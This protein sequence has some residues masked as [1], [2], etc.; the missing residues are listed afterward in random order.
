MQW[1]RFIIDKHVPFA[2]FAGLHISMWSLNPAYFYH[3]GDKNV[4]STM[5]LIQ[6]RFPTLHYHMLQC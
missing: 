3:F 5:M 2:I 6:Q 4:T 1:N